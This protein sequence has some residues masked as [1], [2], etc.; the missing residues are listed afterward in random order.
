MENET[1]AMNVLGRDVI[2]KLPKDWSEVT[3]VNVGTGE[4][5]RKSVEQ[6]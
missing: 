1:P 5:N 6:I 4:S 2:E 3:I